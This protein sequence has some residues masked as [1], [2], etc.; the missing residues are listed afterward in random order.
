MLKNKS[1]VLNF[2]LAAVVVVLSV[3]LVSKS[4]SDIS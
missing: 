3:K 1:I 2:V 4:D